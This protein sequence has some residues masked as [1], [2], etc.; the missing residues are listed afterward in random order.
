MSEDAIGKSRGGSDTRSSE[1]AAH[2]GGHSGSSYGRFLA[3]VGS[4]HGVW[5]GRDDNAT[6]HWYFFG[7]FSFA[8]DSGFLL[9]YIQHI[10][11][12]VPNPSLVKSNSV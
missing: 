9:C 5:R 1:G 8:G 6:R 3:M 2:S 10:S 12:T 7:I 4:I 11:E